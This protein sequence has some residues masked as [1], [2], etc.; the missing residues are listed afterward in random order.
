M[1]YLLFF[2]LGAMVMVHGDDQGLVLPP[3]IACYQVIIIPCGIT[4]N[5][6]EADRKSL[7]AECNAY[8]DRL[9]AAGVRVRVDDR[10]NYS[11]GWKFNHWELKVINFQ[12][13]SLNCVNISCKR[14]NYK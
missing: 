14:S 6:P 11:P 7:Y 4:V 3:R 10:D 12:I 2:L 13:L 1:L 9:K 8:A 5:L